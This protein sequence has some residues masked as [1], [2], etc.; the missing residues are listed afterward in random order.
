MRKLILGAILAAMPTLALAG[1]WVH[2]TSDDDTDIGI[3][4]ET[5]RI[6]GDRRTFWVVVSH[7][8]PQAID[9]DPFDY[10]LLRAEA[11]CRTDIMR[12]NQAILYRLGEDQSAYSETLSRTP[13]YVVPDTTGYHQWSFV[14]GD[15][16][17][18]DRALPTAALFASVMRVANDAASAAGEAARSAAEPIY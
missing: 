4:V 8:Q 9:G 16:W 11:N 5:I 10:M 3:D 18:T 14:C 15:D 13:R 2:V 6:E 1:E 12:M 7:R 17:P